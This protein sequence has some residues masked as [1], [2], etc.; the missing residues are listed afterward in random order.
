V[1]KLKQLF[2]EKHDII[3]ASPYSYP[4][5]GKGMGLLSN[6]R[7]KLQ[8]SP[9]QGI[10]GI[11]A[12]PRKEIPRLIGTELH[13]IAEGKIYVGLIRECKENEIITQCGN[14]IIR[15]I[16]YEQIIGIR[17]PRELLNEFNRSISVHI[18][19]QENRTNVNCNSTTVENIN[20]VMFYSILD[21]KTKDW[22][23]FQNDELEFF[24]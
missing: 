16:K 1:T 21:N 19:H 4:A 14:S 12:I 8:N 18:T 5:F 11:P 24:V 2:M 22:T 23:N 3:I 7:N 10:S 13:F 20:G 15:I 9:L 6:R 17:E